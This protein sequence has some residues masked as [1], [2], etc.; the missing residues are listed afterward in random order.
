[1]DVLQI[2]GFGFSRAFF[3]AYYLMKRPHPASRILGFR[4]VLGTSGEPVPT[5]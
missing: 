3:R 5:S 2:S 4:S 1:M